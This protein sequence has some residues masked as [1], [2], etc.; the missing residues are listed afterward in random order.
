[1]TGLKPIM[2]LSDVQYYENPP[3]IILHNGHLQLTF[4]VVIAH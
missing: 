4:G 3:N 2:E 1:M